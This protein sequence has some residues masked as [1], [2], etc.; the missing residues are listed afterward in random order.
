M[1]DYQVSALGPNSPLVNHGMCIHQ[2]IKQMTYSQVA[3]NEPSPI[4]DQTNIHLAVSQKPLNS[5]MFGNLSQ[6]QK[7]FIDNISLL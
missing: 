1:H 5:L 2:Q 3:S 4:T 7:C 6:I